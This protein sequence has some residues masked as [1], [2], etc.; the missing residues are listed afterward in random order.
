MTEV[1]N[2]P[3]SPRSKGLYSA[4]PISKTTFSFM[5]GMRTTTWGRTYSNCYSLRQSSQRRVS[6]A[7]CEDLL[8]FQ[9]FKWSQR[10]LEAAGMLETSPVL[11]SLPPRAWPWGLV[12]SLFCV[13]SAE[14]RSFSGPVSSSALNPHLR[15]LGEGRKSQR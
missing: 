6:K 1:I 2:L 9:I 10:A 8:R 12:Q 7:H 14:P 4:P 15:A 3:S 13:T 5:P 11:P